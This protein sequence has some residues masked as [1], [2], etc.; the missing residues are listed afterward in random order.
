MLYLWGEVFDDPKRR[1]YV[2][3]DRLDENWI[4]EQRR[5]SLIRALIET[6]RDFHKVRNAKIVVA[7]RLDLLRRVFQMT[8]GAG[9]QEEKY[10][11]D[12]L[13]LR[14]NRPEL[15]EVLDRRIDCLIA[16]RYTKSPVT[17]RDVLPR[18]IGRQDAVGY[19]LDERWRGHVT[20]SCS[21]MHASSTL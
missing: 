8:R 1:Y 15:T 20:L 13:H 12:F 21:S 14:W 4:E 2:V 18:V 6:V 17:Y 19:M 9:F 16:S 10:E 3:I 11:G 7:L 5:Y